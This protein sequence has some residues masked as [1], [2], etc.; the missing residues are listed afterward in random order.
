MKPMQQMLRWMI[1]AVVAVAF[2]HLSGAAMAQGAL[3]QIKLTEKHI[4]GFIAAQKEMGSIFEKI[5]G[6]RPDAKAEAEL[7]T[8]AKKNGFADLNEYEQILANIEIVM[9]GLD[10]QTKTFTD[11][12]VQI[13]KDIEEVKSDK[14]MSEDERKKVLADLNEDLKTAQPLAHPSNIELVKKYYD[15]LDPALP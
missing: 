10:P 12:K 2:A 5:Q 1:A 6:D 7:E 14:S 13:E 3:K 8:I 4:E 9:R 11:L 15:K